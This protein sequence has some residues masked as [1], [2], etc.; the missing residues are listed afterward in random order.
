M[1]GA[2]RL[3]CS[4]IAQQRHQESGDY[5]G[6]HDG[7]KRVGVSQRARTNFHFVAIASNLTPTNGAM[8]RFVDEMGQRYGSI[9]GSLQEGHTAAL[10]QDS[11]QYAPRNTLYDCVTAP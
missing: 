5:E 9:P 4:D 1:C 2:R 8:T 6:D 7:T 11:I 3:G 10:K